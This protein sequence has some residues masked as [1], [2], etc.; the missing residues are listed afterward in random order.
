M[1]CSHCGQDGHNIQTCA[2]VR[3]CSCCN[4]SGHDRR[5]CPNLVLATR[6][7][8]V[9]GP[10]SPQQR[11]HLSR[12]REPLLAHLYW[13]KRWG[14]FE[15]SL[16]AYRAGGGWKLM[17][18]AGH[19]VHAPERPTLNF[20]AVDSTFTGNYEDAAQS[21]GFQHGVLLKQSAIESIGASKGFAFAEVQVGYPHG[22]GETD[23]AEFWRFDLPR[24]RFAAMA[25]L[26][27]ATVFRLATPYE[28]RLRRV[29]VS[30]D[31]VVAWW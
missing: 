28:R 16:K 6:A 9:V 1:A 15:K 19:G 21:R 8:A 2:S 20:F 12:G 29:C 23:P 26:R 18:T 14:Y 31:A 13:P 25:E 11:H 30:Q 4:E 17:A 22:H 3:R 7:G 10:C 27:Y 24:H 5:N